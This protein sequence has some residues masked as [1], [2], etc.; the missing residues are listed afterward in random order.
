M[1]QT[2]AIT[3]RQ[4]YQTYLGGH[5]LAEG[6]KVSYDRRMHIWLSDWLDRPLGEILKEDFDVRRAQ[7]VEKIRKRGVHDG[8]TTAKHVIETLKQ[9][10]R[11]SG[12]AI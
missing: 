6:T 2:Q 4:A 11:F 8:Q 3:L 9:V 5:E 1:R 7:I 12:Y 10:I